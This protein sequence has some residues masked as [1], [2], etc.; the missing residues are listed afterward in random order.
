MVNVYKNLRQK[1]TEVREYTDSSR[2]LETLFT[3]SYFYNVSKQIDWMEKMGKSGP[4]NSLFIFLV[5]DSKDGFHQSKLLESYTKLIFSH[6][7]TRV[8]G[9]RNHLIGQIKT[10][11]STDT[12]FE[13]S[14]LG[15]LLKQ[16]PSDKIELFPRTTGT[17]KVEAKI[18]LDKRWV[19][20]DATTLNESEYDSKILEHLT[21]SEV[22]VGN[23]SIDFDKDKERYIR[24]IQSKSQQF[25]P[26]QP[27]VLVLSLF[28]RTLFIDEPFS[29]PDPNIVAS[30]VGLILRF[31][32]ESLKKKTTDNCDPDCRLTTKETE[33]I[34]D[35]LSN[36]EFK[37]L[38]Y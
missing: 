24:K 20:L 1:M 6:P 23:L 21:Q 31:K 5:V 29:K 8:K 36:E 16:L 27:N 9:D 17:R 37:P 19:Y 30:N 2:T 25:L 33:M 3:D 26:S 18:L 35:L 13:I 15:N 34:F 11:G 14:I 7:A 22:H 4:I 12:L 38:I 10:Q 32:R 28:G